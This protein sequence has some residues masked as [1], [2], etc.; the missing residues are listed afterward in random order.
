MDSRAIIKKLEQ[1][2]WRHV[3]MVGSHHIFE[4]PDYPE[5]VTVPH[6]KKGSAPG[7]ASRHSQDRADR[8]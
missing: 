5:I 3:R 6:P 8:T 1:R 4:H 7:D 2:G